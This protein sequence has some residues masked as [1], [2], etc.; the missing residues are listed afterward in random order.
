W[1]STSSSDAQAN[2]DKHNCKRCGSLVCDPCSKTKRSLPKFGLH[3]P[4]RICDK[5]YFSGLV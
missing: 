2:R 3:D 1:A 5:C 4:A